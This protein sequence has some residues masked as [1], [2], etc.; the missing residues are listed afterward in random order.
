ME[1]YRHIRTVPN[2]GYINELNIGGGTF[3][4]TCFF[5]SVRDYLNN[6]Y[7]GAR[8][9][10]GAGEPQIPSITQLRIWAGWTENRFDNLMVDTETHFRNIV[11]LL[12]ELNNHFRCNFEIHIHNTIRLRI[13]GIETVPLHNIIDITH[14]IPLKAL[15]QNRRPPQF[16]DPRDKN[17]VIYSTTNARELVNPYPRCNEVIHI[18]NIGNYHYEYIDN[19]DRKPVL[20]DNVLPKKPESIKPEP[21]KSFIDKEDLA[22]LIQ[23][24]EDRIQ[25]VNKLIDDT[26]KS[27]SIKGI[28]RE[29]FEI[30]KASQLSYLYNQL[31]NIQNELDKTLTLIS[32]S[33][34]PY[35]PIDIK[36]DEELAMQLQMDEIETSSKPSIREEEFDPVLKRLI[37]GDIA[38]IHMPKSDLDLARELQEQEQLEYVINLSK[39][40][41]TQMGGNNYKLDKEIIKI[42]EY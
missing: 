5:L 13:D 37:D 2:N 31:G 20:L 41:K 19:I 12:N 27:Y 28:D 11:L 36:K 18:Y 25:N 1:N 30:I 26:N 33:S 16:I 42:L 39:L 23:E 15:Y 29:E 14:Y 32:D 34:S 40:S 38:S 22:R 3:T 4:N 35:I 8:A 10:T 9:G 21:K 7:G 17:I 6:R 24:L